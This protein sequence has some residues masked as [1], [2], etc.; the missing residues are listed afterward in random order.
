[1][2]VVIGRWRVTVEGETAPE[3]QP[4][5]DVAASFA[6]IFATYQAPIRRYL[7]SLVRDPALAED[8]TQETFTKA[9][10]ALGRSTPTHLNGWLY[11]IATNTAFAVFR[12]RLLAF[13]SLGM[14]AGEEVEDAAGDPG[15][16]VGERE[17]VRLALARLPKP[18]AAC[19]LLRFQQGLT[20]PELAV[21]LGV[22]EP[23]AKKRLSRARA[24]FR[25][26]YLSLSEEPPT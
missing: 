15:R 14:L 11:A 21:V 3:A 5:R 10:Q 24:A 18:D 7:A 23:A 16:A 4:A 20:Y 26:I 9:Y 2:K 8:L 19:L 17:I 6:E 13:L 25:E 1:M 22:T 12:R